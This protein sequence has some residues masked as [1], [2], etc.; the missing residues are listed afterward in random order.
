MKNQWKALLLRNK[1]KFNHI[2]IQPQIPDFLAEVDLPQ[3][4]PMDS[5]DTLRL[6][7]VIILESYFNSSLLRERHSWLDVAQSLAQRVSP[8][9]G[10][11]VTRDDLSML[12]DQLQN[13]GSELYLKAL[14]LV[15]GSM[16]SRF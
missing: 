9:D 2:Q 12:L 11:I 4:H 13:P 8:G 3:A 14:E 15:I 10:D 7:A 5:A 16:R 6:K 1:K